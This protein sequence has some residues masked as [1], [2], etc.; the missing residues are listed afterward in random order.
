MSLQAIKVRKIS[1]DDDKAIFGYKPYSSEGIIILDLTDMKI[2]IEKCCMEDEGGEPLYGNKA[3]MH[4]ALKY[5]E[6]TLGD[7]FLI[8]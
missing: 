8:H 3:K 4:I 1:E 6:K 5:E 2:R 7:E